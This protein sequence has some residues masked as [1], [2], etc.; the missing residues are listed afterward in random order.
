LKAAVTLT[1]REFVARREQQKTAEL[2]GVLD[3]DACADHKPER[4]RT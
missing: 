1:L 2:F 4:I 3:L